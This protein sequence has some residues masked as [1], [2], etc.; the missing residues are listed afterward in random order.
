LIFGGWNLYIKRLKLRNF[1]NYDHLDISF[2]KNF[3]ILS[4]NNGQGKTNILE[5][6]FM[7][8]AARSHRTSKDQ[9]MVM[10]GRESFLISLDFER[11]QIDKNIEISFSKTEKKKVR[12]NG[13]PLKKIGGLMGN[14]NAVVFSPE[15]LLIIKEGPSERRRFVDI[16]IS[17]LKPS[18][19]YDLQ[20]YNRTLTQRNM[21]LKEIQN[22]RNL[23]DTL[24]IWNNNL[25]TIGSRIIKTRY[26]FVK[27]L[28]KYAEENHSR[29]TDG[30][31][32]L[33]IRYA[34]SVQ[35]DENSSIEDIMLMFVRLLEKSMERELQKAST[36][37]GPQRDDYEIFLNGG[38]IKLYGS[39]GQQRS[40]VLSM[41]L[42]EID[43]ILEETGEYPVLLLDDVMSELD[44]KR[45]LYLLKNLD[46]IQTF[47]TCTDSGFFKDLP[48]SSASYYSIVSGTAKKE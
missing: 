39:Q 22:K 29:I 30:A 15:D 35:I 43:L 46:G 16:T 13:I 40:A 47:I 1:R 7:C 41:K 2:G 36:L 10:L 19:F 14:L 20:Q 8:A 18:Y 25:A 48:G 31:E 17:Q 23:I 27:R 3:N 6:I 28:G 34:P 4:G 12:I 42:S 44:G 9:D 32:K 45:Q 37:Y 11:E 33:A 24:E 5:A 26:E 21:L 38:S